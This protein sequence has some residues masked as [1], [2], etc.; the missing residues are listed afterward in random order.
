MI[1]LKLAIKLLKIMKNPKINNLLANN[2]K[3]N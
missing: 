2:L 1:R 3:L